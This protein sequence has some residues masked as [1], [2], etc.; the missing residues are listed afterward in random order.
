[1]SIFCRL[2]EYIVVNNTCT[3][4]VNQKDTVYIYGL[5][6]FRLMIA[7]GRKS[8]QT[9]IRVSLKLWH[10]LI[11]YHLIYTLGAISESN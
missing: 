5:V 1:M 11:H 2:R 8:S 6:S 3:G 9:L 10:I 4:P 7:T